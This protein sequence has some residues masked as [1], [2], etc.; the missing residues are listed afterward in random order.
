MDF[1]GLENQRGREFT[2]GSNPTPSAKMNLH[3]ADCKTETW[4]HLG[5]YPSNTDILPIQ[6]VSR[7]IIDRRIF[8]LQLSKIL[9]IF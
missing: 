4:T 6:E 1:I 9:D 2:V 8:I 3:L 7:P 5:H